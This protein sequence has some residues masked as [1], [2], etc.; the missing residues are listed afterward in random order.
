MSSQKLESLFRQTWRAVR[1]TVRFLWG[2]IPRAYAV[3]MVLLISWLTW[4]AVSY[5]IS[6]LASDDG[7]PAQITGLPTRLDRS[8][9]AASRTQFAA[10]DSAE[11]PRSPLAHYHRL[12]NWIQPDR[13]NDCTRSGCHNP[14]PHSKR[15][16]VRAF[17]NM[18]ATSVHCG[19]CHFD[20]SQKPRPLVWYGIE[21]GETAPL[22]AILQAFDLLTSDSGRRWR[23]APTEADQSRL[24]TL[25][26]EA[27]GAANELPVLL[28]LAD[29]FAAV[30]PASD[31]FQ[32]LIDE[33]ASS[34]PRHFRGEYGAKLAIRADG[35]D[36]PMLAHP[37]T[38]AAVAA[39]LAAKDTTDDAERERLL[40]A[41]HP[42]RRENALNCTDCHSREGSLIDFAQLG[43]P[44]ARIDLLVNPVIFRMIEHIAAGRVF[45]L[46]EVVGPE[47]LP[48]PMPTTRPPG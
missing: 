19:V 32:R 11:F 25:L 35:S 47:P 30:H 5:L 10:L 2:A 36:S 3:A 7:P 27:A 31:A 45:R 46:P 4:M 9:Q 24:V 8:V 20:I 23:A 48:P 44:E 26:R 15:K 42:L 38:D 34:L 13:F 28:R 41:V 40:K 14:M 6:S 1:L 21:T 37:Q 39:Y 33:A 12:D 29:H 43:Y 17:L 16:E 18:H 22:P